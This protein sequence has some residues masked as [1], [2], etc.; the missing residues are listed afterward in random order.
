[1]EEYR[2][3]NYLP[4]QIRR[5]IKLTF[6]TGIIYLIFKGILLLCFPNAIF[7]SWLNRLEIIFTVVF[8][9]SFLLF[10]LCKKY[11]DEMRK[12]IIVKGFAVNLLI[13]LG[14]LII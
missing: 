10:M 2:F 14:V 8:A 7:H 5:Y 1:M 12:S 4:I 13:I 11:I 3:G 6:I 9:L